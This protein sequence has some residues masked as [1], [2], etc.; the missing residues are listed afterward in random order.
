M[1]IFINFKD[2][3]M[4]TFYF[5]SGT[6]LNQFNDSTIYFINNNEKSEL[7]DSQNDTVHAITGNLTVTRGSYNHFYT[8]NNDI[9]FNNGTGYNFINTQGTA[10]IFGADSLVM[11]LEATN[12]AKSALFVGSTGHEVFKAGNS[13]AAIQVWANNDTSHNSQLVAITGSGDDL[14]AAGTGQSTLTGGAGNN[15]FAFFKNSDDG[16][17]TLITDFY[18]SSGNKIYLANYGFNENDVS[19]LLA[20]SQNVFKVADDG[21]THVYANLNLGNHDI[22]IKDVSVSGLHVSQFSV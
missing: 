5:N 3:M 2:I 15:T 7:R 1:T 14:L 11:E 6:S 22:L 16:G 21:K 4:G 17:Q 10:Q 19:N 9:N 20:N 13:T 8:Y 12:T 18:K